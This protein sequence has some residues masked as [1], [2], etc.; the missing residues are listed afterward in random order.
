MSNLDNVALWK[1]LKEL[2]MAFIFG[3]YHARE[4]AVTLDRDCLTYAAQ[5]AKKALGGQFDVR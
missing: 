2:L 4:L 5:P 1:K 3:Q